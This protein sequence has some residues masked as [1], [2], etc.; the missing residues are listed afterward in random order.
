MIPRLTTCKSPQQMTG[1]LIKSYY[2]ETRQIDPDKI[3]VVSVMPCTAKKFESQREEMIHKGISD[4]D[5]VLTTRE[6]SRMIKLHGINLQQ[7]ESEPADIPMASRSASSKIAGVSGGE[8]EALI[9]TLSFKVT[10]KELNY[11]KVHEARNVKGRKEFKIEMGDK[12]F[13]ILYCKWIKT[14]KTANG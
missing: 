11:A 5:I 10:G 12:V 3:V 2:A 14:S 6:L 8:T 4:V 13:R 7:I 9:R 1:A